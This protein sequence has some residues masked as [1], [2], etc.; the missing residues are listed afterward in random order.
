MKAGSNILREID[1]L[2]SP[3]AGTFED[4]RPDFSNKGK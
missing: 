4:N 3:M 1:Q 2:N